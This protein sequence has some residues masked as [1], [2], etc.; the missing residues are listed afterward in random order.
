MLLSNLFGNE[1]AEKVL[2]FLAS[3]NEGYAKKIS[4]IFG[5]SLSQVQRQLLRFEREGILVSQLK[6][7]TRV[8]FWNPRYM[9]LKEL[10]SLLDRALV[11]LPQEFQEK[12]FRIRIRPRRVGKP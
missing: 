2:L 11:M 6:G 12:Y 7:K 8:F 9:F 3:Y 1:T 4:D 5:I 10:L